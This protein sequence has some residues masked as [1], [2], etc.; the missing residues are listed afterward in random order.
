ML[1][2]RFEERQDDRAVPFKVTLQ[3]VN[4]TRKKN[5]LIYLFSISTD[6]LSPKIPQFFSKW[7]K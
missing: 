1:E 5:N 6:C 3:S 7:K 4:E 2:E